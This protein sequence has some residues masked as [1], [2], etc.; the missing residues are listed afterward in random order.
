MFKLVI[1]KKK[2][3]AKISGYFSHLDINYLNKDSAK[4]IEGTK[5]MS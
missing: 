3:Y 4:M 1:D 2:R 5:Q